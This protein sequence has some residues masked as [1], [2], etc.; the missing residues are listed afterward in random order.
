VLENL[1]GGRPGL[2]L[3][4]GVTQMYFRL[5]PQQLAARSG[6][7]EL[8]FSQEPT[9]GEEVLPPDVA[10]GVLQS[11]RTWRLLKTENGYFGADLDGPRGL[12][13]SAVPEARALVNVK[14]SQTELGQYGLDGLVG[15]YAPTSYS[16]STSGPYAVGVSPR[17]LQPENASINARLARDPALR[18]RVSVQPEPSS[19]FPATNGQEKKA[20]AE[21]D[22]RQPKVTTAD[23]R[24]AIHRATGMPVVSDFYTRLYTPDTVSVGEQSL[25][26]ALNRLCDTVQTRWNRESDTPGTSAWLQFRS[27]NYH[28]DRLKEV[29]N[30]FLTRWA[31][32]RR[33]RGH[34]P[35][36]DLIEMAGL[37][38]AQLEASSMAEGIRE[39]WGLPEWDLARDWAVLPHLR[40]LALLTPAQRQEIQSIRG[41]PFTKMTLAQ[42]QAFFS[43]NLPGNPELHSLEQLIGTAL[44]VPYTQPGGFEWHPP[45]I[46]SLRWAVRPGPCREGTWLP[47][48]EVR[49]PTREA[50]LEAVR[51]IDPAIRN[52][53]RATVQAAAARALEPVTT[54]PLPEEAQIVPTRLDLATIYI[55]GTAKQ[56]LIF[57]RRGSQGVSDLDE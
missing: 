5:S 8:R 3:A 38:D 10:R 28:H 46:H 4:W 37:P 26:D 54:P 53:I 13:L 18:L 47:V 19:F 17:T 48:P 6:G 51:R 27:I 32:T 49:E 33:E 55:P 9:S 1:G 35:L 52:A 50:A 22:E 2:G 30:R 16:R 36:E 41:L 7:R 40:F 29:P 15:Y 39:W 57:W 25:F 56:H 12:P 21:G 45:A 42:Q 24:E 23:V 11:L 14:L 34:L 43:R 31:S 20:E 44:R